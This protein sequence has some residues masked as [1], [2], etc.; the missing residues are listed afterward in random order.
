[1]GGEGKGE[2]GEG[3]TLQMKNVKVAHR[4]IEWVP[5]RE[6]SKGLRHKAYKQERG[7]K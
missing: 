5:L 1:M 7:N 4:E 6:R 2:E 3:R